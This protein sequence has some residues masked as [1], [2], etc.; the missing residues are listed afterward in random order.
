MNN[1]KHI[2]AYLV[3]IALITAVMSSIDSSTAQ[4]SETMTKGPS[5]I[6]NGIVVE[7]YVITA[8]RIN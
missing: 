4:Y 1:N 2:I 5:T 3:F 8:K 6:E 7:Q